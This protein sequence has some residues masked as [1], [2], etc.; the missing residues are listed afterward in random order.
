M[1]ATVLASI[2][3]AQVCS[4]QNSDKNNEKVCEMYSFS[5]AKHHKKLHKHT[6]EI[7]QINNIYLPRRHL[8]F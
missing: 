7:V 8:Q 1:I 2:T 5:A 4:S 6:W 3:T